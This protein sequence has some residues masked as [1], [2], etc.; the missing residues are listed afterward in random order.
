M[1][2]GAEPIG[3][4]DGIKVDFRSGYTDLPDVKKRQTSTQFI[5]SKPLAGRGRYARYDQEA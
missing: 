5:P 1:G 4:G 3:F 2:G